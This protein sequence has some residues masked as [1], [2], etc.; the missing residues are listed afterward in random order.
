MQ[1][2]DITPGAGKSFAGIVTQLLAVFDQL[3]LFFVTLALVLFMWGVVQYIKSPVQSKEGKNVYTK[4]SA[5]L[6][7]LI[8]LFVLF[9]I[10]GILRLM[11][12]TLDYAVA[13]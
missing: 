11:L 8:A 2:L 6:W 1:P 10:W 7:S 13:G 9:S 12:N 5:M 3:I 4:R